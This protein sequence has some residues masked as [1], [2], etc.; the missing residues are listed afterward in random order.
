[1]I[2]LPAAAR[3]VVSPAARRVASLI[4]CLTAVE[5]APFL[6]TTA[7]L[8]MSQASQAGRRA[9]RELLHPRRFHPRT[10]RNWRLDPA[11][12]TVRQ[13]SWLL[14]WTSMPNL[15][16]LPVSGLAPSLV[17][18]DPADGAIAYDDRCYV[19]FATP[20]VAEQTELAIGE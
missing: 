2:G 10:Y 14:L 8:K 3:P 4:H 5:Q 20:G 18:E 17:C 1:M 13:L 11:Y 9:R 16:R 15:W 12:R 6:A 7:D 19:R